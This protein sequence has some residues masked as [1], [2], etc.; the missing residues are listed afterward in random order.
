M[1]D[2]ELEFYYFKFHDADKNA[3]LDGLEML[4]A[5]LHTIHEDHVHDDENNVDGGSGE[6]HGPA[7]DDTSYFVGLFFIISCLL[8]ERHIRCILMRSGFI[9]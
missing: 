5:I 4:Q 1:S 6:K 2:E 3:K 7:P 8:E 9:T